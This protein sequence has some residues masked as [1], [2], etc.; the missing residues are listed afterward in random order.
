MQEIRL[1]LVRKNY[2][3]DGYGEWRLF[4]VN[5]D[6]DIDEELAKKFDIQLTE[7]D[8]RLDISLSLKVM[9]RF[10]YKEVDPERLCELL[11]R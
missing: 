4:T 3:W 7:E 5:A 6:E 2:G 10:D 11:G 1:F 8:K 9:G